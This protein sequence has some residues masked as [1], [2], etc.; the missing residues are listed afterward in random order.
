MQR[1][2]FVDTRRE[3]WARLETLS[4]RLGRGNLRRARPDELL[5]FG[6]LY[7]RAASDLA[8]ARR[9]FPGDRVTEHLN[10]LVARAHPIVYRDD[11]VDAGRIKRFI[12]SG[13]PEAYRRAGG[14][15]A[16]AF[17]ISL[18]AAVIA[19][20]LVALNPSLAD[21]LLMPSGT[22]QSLR[23]VM[24]H[25][26]LWVKAAT[27][28]HSVAASLIVTNN[29]RVAFFAFAGGMLVTV[30]AV[31]I[32]A[33]NGIQLGAVAA[34]VAQYGLSWDFWSFVVPHGVIELSVIFI[35]GGAGMMIGDS[36][37]RPGL[38]RRSEALIEA[39]RTAAY[40]LVGCVVLLMVA[41]TIE[42]FL[43]PSNLSS[44]IKFAVGGVSGV[45]LYSYLLLPRT[46]SRSR[47]TSR[48]TRG[49]N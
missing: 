47:A 31:Y 39:A 25:H 21:D 5:E 12:V 37:L 3:H 46:S 7:R 10:R 42:S 14:Y 27:E 13:Y 34:L 9:D 32:L 26:H 36:I 48:S 33:F 23:S 49:I 16:L 4:R 41:G 17:A 45:A 2:R 8:V 6:D 24:E 15:I 40:L 30:G 35:A 22:A 29:V 28:N 1:D 38:R 43:S 44:Y 20:L 18:V 11:P 19:A